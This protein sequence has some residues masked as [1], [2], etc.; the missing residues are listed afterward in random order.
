MQ[1]LRNFAI[2]DMETQIKATLPPEKIIARGVFHR[3]RSRILA[4][5]HQ[6]TVKMIQKYFYLII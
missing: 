3:I 6:Q 5:N 4:C 1:H 2:D